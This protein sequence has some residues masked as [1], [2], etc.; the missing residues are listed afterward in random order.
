MDGGKTIEDVGYN[1]SQ[2]HQQQEQYSAPK[3]SYPEFPKTDHAADSFPKQNSIRFPQTEYTYM[4]GLKSY[5][6]FPSVKEHQE[7]FGGRRQLDLKS[8]EFSLPL[9]VETNL[10]RCPVGKLSAASVNGLPAPID[11]SKNVGANNF[12][13]TFVPSLKR[14][15]L[16]AAKYSSK[17]AEFGE[18]QSFSPRIIVLDDKSNAQNSEDFVPDSPR[19]SG[20]EASTSEN[21]WRP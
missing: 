17:P 19:N 3:F 11:Y 20:S 1:L 8:S 15:R 21:V 18:S 7:T 6:L 4:D 12:Q 14:R 9:T 10:E 13:I 16:E 5:E 2:K